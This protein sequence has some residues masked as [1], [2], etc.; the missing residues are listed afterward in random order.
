MPDKKTVLGVTFTLVFFILINTSS[1]FSITFEE[2]EKVL[3]GSQKIEIEGISPGD[4]KALEAYL[5]KPKG[6]GPFPALIALH[7]AGG[8]SS[9]QLW[10]AKEISK[11][12][13][14]FYLLIITAQGISCVRLNR[15]MKIRLVAKL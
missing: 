9:Y 15:M 7:G 8:I 14:L 2:Y 13:T 12:D 5:Y 11:T 3:E 1:A 10:W 6:K 4:G